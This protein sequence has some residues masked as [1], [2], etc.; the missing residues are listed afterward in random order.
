MTVNHSPAIFVAA[1]EFNVTLDQQGGV[2]A[3]CH[4]V[5]RQMVADHDE[6]GS[7]RGVLCIDCKAGKG[8]LN[9]DPRLLRNMLDYLHQQNQQIAD[10]R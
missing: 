5:S 2:C 6:T 7:L 8:M 9:N 3:V 1:G 4:T 10:R